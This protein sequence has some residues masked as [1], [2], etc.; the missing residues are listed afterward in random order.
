MAA[1]AAAPSISASIL[2][3]ICIPE[4]SRTEGFTDGKPCQSSCKTDG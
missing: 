4:M 1:I 2:V 3:N